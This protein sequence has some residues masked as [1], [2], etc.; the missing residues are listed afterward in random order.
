VTDVWL[1]DMYLCNPLPLPI[2]SNPFFLLPRQQFRSTLDLFRFAC[3]IIQ[4][5]YIFKKQIDKETLP[6]DFGSGHG[7][8]YPLCMQTYKHFFTACRIPSEDKDKL[9]IHNANVDHIVVACRNQTHSSRECKRLIATN[10]ESWSV[11]MLPTG[12]NCIGLIP[13]NRNTNVIIG[14]KNEEFPEEDEIV[15]QLRLIW[16]LSKE[17]EATCPHIGLLTTENRKVWGT[18]R[19]NLIKRPTNQESLHFI[20]TCLYILCLDDCISAKVAT[21]KNQRRDSAVEIA[22][23]EPAFMASHLLHGG[24]TDYYTANRYFDKFMQFV[25]GR[26]GIC[27]CLCE[28]SASEGITVLRFIDDFLAFLKERPI[29]NSSSMQ[30]KDS[31]KGITKN[32]N[33]LATRSV[34]RDLDLHILCFNEFGKTFIKEEKMSPDAFIQL[35]LQLTYYKVHK[36]LVSSYESAGLRQFRL[37]RV[38]NIRANTVD[39]LVWVRAMCDEIPDT[40]DASKIEFFQ[41]AMKKQVEILKYT[42]AGQGPDNHLLGLREMAKK[43]NNELPLLFREKAYKEFLNFRLSTSQLP[44]ENGVI[45]GYGPVVPDGYGCSYNT[46]ANQIVFCITSFYSSPETGSNFFASSLEG[47]LLQMRELCYKLKN[48]YSVVDKVPNKL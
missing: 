5:S 45:V 8:G 11:V 14:L 3:R 44:T 29:D 35:A 40:T 23:M 15:E 27:G 48:I 12:G 47:S 46:S 7:K 18:V 4:F 2:N 43:N 24:G 19:N 36:R 9:Y 30:R 34:V 16:Y 22:K 6:Q 13:V 1:D 37:G 31:M 10:I 17:N 39:A 26:D 42:I 21:A 41:K 28:H 25:V 33:L 20:E 32:N 38:D